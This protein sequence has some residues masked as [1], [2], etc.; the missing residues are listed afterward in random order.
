MI[1]IDKDSSEFRSRLARTYVGVQENQEKST[2]EP[3]AAQTEHKLSVEDLEKAREAEARARKAGEMAYEAAVRAR[4]ALAASAR[5]N[6]Q[7]AQEAK[8]KARGA[9]IA[10]LKA[11]KQAKLATRIF[12]EAKESGIL[13]PGPA[14]T[15]EG[16]RR[17]E[18]APLN[19]PVGKNKSDQSVKQEARPEESNAKAAGPAEEKT[20]N[21]TE[22]ARKPIPVPVPVAVGA[23]R[24]PKWTGGDNFQGKMN[25]FL[26]NS[27]TVQA[28][29]LAETLC[30]VHNLQVVV[31]GSIEEGT[32]LIVL[33]DQPVPLVDILGQMPEVNEVTQFGPGEIQLSLKK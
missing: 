33:A 25:I 13:T 5:A 9:R 28:S 15:E 27:N 18:K 19:A 10:A 11:K 23:S 29:S 24:E 6:K 2:P 32:K 16:N 17:D 8:I 26:R 30:T 1:N 4:E 14:D 3:P 12:A 7:L 22:T 20:A 31:S 21:Q